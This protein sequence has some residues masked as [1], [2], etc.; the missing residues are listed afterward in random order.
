[1]SPKTKLSPPCGPHSVTIGIT[2]L[3]L[4]MTATVLEMHNMWTEGQAIPTHGNQGPDS[5]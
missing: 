3:L 4:S 1:M 2:L 5:I